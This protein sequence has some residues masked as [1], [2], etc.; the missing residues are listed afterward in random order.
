[1]IFFQRRL[2][3][4]CYS[5]ACGTWFPNRSTQH[6]TNILFH[7]I[8]EQKNHPTMTKSFSDRSVSIG[9]SLS[10]SVLPT[11]DVTCKIEK[12]VGFRKGE[13]YASRCAEIGFASQQQAQNFLSGVLHGHVDGIVAIL[14]RRE[15]EIK[16][17]SFVISIQPLN[18]C[19]PSDSLFDV[20]QPRTYV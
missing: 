13:T 5:S 17:K 18:E 19:T 20:H 14:K 3:T 8:F 9:L 15:N 11:V 2:I 10:V 12:K 1:M 16:R 7:K 6:R 4:R